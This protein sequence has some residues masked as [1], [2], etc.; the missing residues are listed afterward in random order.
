MILS[1]SFCLFCYPYWIFVV[2][3]CQGIQNA[4]EAYAV[5][6]LVAQPCLTLPHGLQP[7]RLLCPWDSPGKITGVGCHALLQGIFPT[8][9]SNPDLLHCRHVLYQLCYQRSPT[10]LQTQSIITIQQNCFQTVIFFTLRMCIA[11]V[12]GIASSDMLLNWEV[13]T[14]EE[15]RNQTSKKPSL[16]RLKTQLHCTTDSAS[17]S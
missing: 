7:A 12:W 3:I 17:V 11:M 9:G 1:F 16:N 15:A 13:Y 10:S 8:Q 6:C 2:P 5:L 4:L 14:E